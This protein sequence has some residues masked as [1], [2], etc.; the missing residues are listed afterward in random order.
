MTEEGLSSIS[1][2]LVVQNKYGGVP[3]SVV[4]FYSVYADAVLNIM[5]SGDSSIIV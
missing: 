3:A 1:S 5:D 4:E 2:D